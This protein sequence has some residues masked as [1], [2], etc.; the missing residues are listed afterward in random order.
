MLNADN[1]DRAT[2]ALAQRVLF[3]TLALALSGTGIGLFG[4]SKGLVTGI[5]AVL[6]VC[7]FVFSLG[8]LAT[9]LVSRSVTL[10]AV[11][12]AA[13]VFFS[14]NLCTGIFIA[15]Y[16]RGEH[17]NVFVYLLWFFPLLGFN[18]LVNRPSIGR[19]LA[20]ILIVAPLLLIGCLM[21]RWMVVLKLEQRV[22]LAVYCVSYC[23]Y[24]VTIDLVAQYREKYLIEQERVGS[25]KV[26]VDILESISDCFISLDSDGRLIYLNDAAC[27]ELAVERRT[28]LNH[29]LSIAVPGFLSEAAITELR[30]A[31]I[32]TF[33]SFFEALSEGSGNW[34]DLRCFF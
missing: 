7:S 32:R 23:C 12:T 1:L 11:A 18:K 8:S 30:A 9:L 28:V 29:T 5:E 19:L 20:K 10:Q 26:A 25:L 31:S 6:V 21:P 3:I 2:A 14:I 17:L 16:G 27:T 34:Y 15:I 24:A 33:A 13:T 22:L 4:I